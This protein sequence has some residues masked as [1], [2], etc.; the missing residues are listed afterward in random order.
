MPRVVLTRLYGLA[1]TV[2]DCFKRRNE[3]GQDVALGA[4]KDAR[5]TR[6]APADDLWRYAQACRVVNVMLP[7]MKAGAHG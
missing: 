1:K 6:K 2:V 4:L 5:R 7:Y 3:I